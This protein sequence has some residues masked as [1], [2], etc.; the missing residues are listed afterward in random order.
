M[1][2]RDTCFRIYWTLRRLVAPRLRSSQDAYAELLRAQVHGNVEWLDLGCGHQVLPDWHAE[3][4]KRLVGTCK[5][6]VGVDCDLRSLA[7]HRTIRLR[8][9]GDISHLP[10][11]DDCFTLVT[12]NMVVEHL[13]NPDLQLAEI[14]RVLKTGGLCIL[15]TPNAYGYP[16]LL[17]RSVPRAV[18]NR[19]IRTL[20]G[21]SVEDAF[22]AYYRANTQ[23]RLKELSEA[24]S[25][26]IVSIAMLTS[27]ALFA[28]LPPVAAIELL[29]IRILMTKPFRGLRP[30]ILA[31]L[32]KHHVA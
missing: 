18:R 8:V 1:A 32:R 28:V 21:R 6:V 30:I 2:L 14:A 7:N 15:L 3:A 11:K 25:L 22:R 17:A 19:A 20:D 4:E 16:A 12:A 5:M 26:E 10:F 31:V 9:R 27:D 29:L 24:N 23:R 13:Q